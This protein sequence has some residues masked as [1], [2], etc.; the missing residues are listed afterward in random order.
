MI[1]K[2]TN[3]EQLQ[4]F[5]KANDRLKFSVKVYYVL[6]FVE[7]NPDY[8]NDC[9]A[10]WCSDKKHFISNSTLLG[11]TLSIKPN[12][13]NTNFRSHSFKIIPVKTLELTNEFNELIDLRNWK[14]RINQKYNFTNQSYIEEINL[15]PCQPMQGQKTLKSSIFNQNFG[16]IISLPLNYIYQPS[17]QLQLT[18]QPQQQ[19]QA[20]PVQPPQP[21]QVQVSSLS[22]QQPVPK[23]VSPLEYNVYKQV[24]KETQN[25]LSEDPN[26]LL[27]TVIL[28]NKI[29]RNTEKNRSLILH[30]TRDWIKVAGNVSKVEPDVITDAIISNYQKYP[31]SKN[32][33][34]NISYLLLSQTES[35]QQEEVLS[36]D[37]FCE[38][39]LRYGPISKAAGYIDD[40]TI[41]RYEQDFPFG[42]SEQEIQSNDSQS[43]L[44]SHFR[45]YFQPSFSSIVAKKILDGQ[46]V[47]AWLL[48]PSS[49]PSKFTVQ[50]KESEKG[51]QII[52]ATYIEF[53]PL[54]TDDEKPFCVSIENVGMVGANS[55]NEILFDIMKLD[56]ENSISLNIR[57]K[58]SHSSLW[59]DQLNEGSPLLLSPSQLDS[60]LSSSQRYF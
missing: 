49:T 56:A 32:L 58:N 22:M 46:P 45:P 51:K 60:Q 48:R 4:M 21:P 29:S 11:K 15:I 9:G 47:H 34:S 12:T 31:E 7:K 13:I 3:P 1:D 6:Q 57:E 24:P 35:T 53:N 54:A 20:P 19:I 55:W 37:Q 33:R 30:A 10:S 25:L 42:S 23:R 16:P 18:L 26:A 43:L 52:Y 41:S 14:K 17:Q 39:F 28:M 59:N 38:F 44:P 27:N 2:F 8:I 50:Y 5:F 36:F 40:L